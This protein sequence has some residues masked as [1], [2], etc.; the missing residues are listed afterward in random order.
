MLMSVASDTIEGHANARSLRPCW[1][2]R[3]LLPLGQYWS[4]WP[5]MPPEP[6][7]CP[8]RASLKNHVWTCV[9]PASGVSND[10]H[11]LCCHGGGGHR[12][13]A[14]WNLRGCA[15]LALPLTV[16][17]MA[18]SAPGWT[19]QQENWSHTPWESWPLHSALRRD[20]PT[21][22]QGYGSCPRWHG[23]RRVDSAPTWEWWSQ[24]PRSTSTVNTQIYILGLAMTHP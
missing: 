8:G 23:P 19:L 2:L 17:R 7:W 3:V 16:S 20:S 4:G 13:H 12:N 5:V 24:W 18:D 14:Y 11:D 21:S 1:C 15:K 22:H 9:P 10:L 6:L